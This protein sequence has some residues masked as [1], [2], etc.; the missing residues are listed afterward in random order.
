MTWP[1]SELRYMPFSFVV[2]E[3][4]ATVVAQLFAIIYIFIQL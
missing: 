2:S 3:S 4:R 1:F